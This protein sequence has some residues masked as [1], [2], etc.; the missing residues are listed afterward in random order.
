MDDYQDIERLAELF[1]DK[2]AIPGIPVRLG[3]DAILGLI[4]V[5]GDLISAIVSFYI[6]MRAAQAGISL[7][8]ILH[9]IFNVVVD[10]F[11]GVVPI[12]GDI[13]DIGWRA[14]RKNIRLLQKAL[15]KK[16]A[17]SEFA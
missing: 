4:P 13:A 15:K 11:I 9:M 3:L 10:L 16:M 5:A 17:S 12:F 1:D 6:V 7:F 8:T 2:F 14:N